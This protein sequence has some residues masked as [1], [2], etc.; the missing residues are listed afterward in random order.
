MSSSKTSFNLVEQ[1]V[2]TLAESQGFIQSVM[3]LTS[4]IAVDFAKAD[5]GE[6]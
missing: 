3:D 5:N 6:C 4:K 1:S 2:S